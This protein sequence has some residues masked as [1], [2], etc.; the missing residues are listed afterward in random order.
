MEKVIPIRKASLSETDHMLLY[1]IS[2]K[3]IENAKISLLSNHEKKLINPY[4]TFLRIR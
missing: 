4:T 1:N 2:D 3:S